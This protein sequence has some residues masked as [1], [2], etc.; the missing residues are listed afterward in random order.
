MTPVLAMS[1]LVATHLTTDLINAAEIVQ[2]AAEAL[3]EDVSEARDATRY[4]L[5]AD[6]ISIVLESPRSTRDCL[7]LA[8]PALT[9]MSGRNRTLIEMIEAETSNDAY[10]LRL[11]KLL[12]RALIWRPES[13]PNPLE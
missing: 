11:A 2:A 1:R 10:R 12:F 3:A 4:L 9:E 7:L 13:F 8:S 6:R 5:A